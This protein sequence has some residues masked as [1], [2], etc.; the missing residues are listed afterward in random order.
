[1]L[2]T[3]DTTLNDYCSAIPS[4][5]GVFISFITLSKLLL[6]LPML[7]EIN[8]NKMEDLR[9]DHPFFEA[10]DE[11]SFAYMAVSLGL[12]PQAPVIRPYG[13]TSPG[14]HRQKMDDLVEDHPFCFC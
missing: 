4:L 13:R 12:K 14:L 8:R 7:P 2:A 11:E 3:V 9:K 1:M 5:L 6:L 10:L